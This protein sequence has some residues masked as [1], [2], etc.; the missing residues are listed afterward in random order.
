MPA[1]AFTTRAGTTVLS[2]T[3]QNA[4]QTREGD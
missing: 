4:C 1:R 2:K 3:K